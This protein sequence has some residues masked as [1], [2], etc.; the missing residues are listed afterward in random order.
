MA[1]LLNRADAFAE[2]VLW[3]DTATDLRHIIGGAGDRIGFF[4]A[5]LGGEFQPVRDIVG[6]RAALLAEGHAALR[7]ARGLCLHAFDGVIAVNLLEVP[8]ARLGRPFLRHRAFDFDELQHFFCHYRLQG[9]E[10]C[11]CRGHNHL[12]RGF[13]PIKYHIDIYK[14]VGF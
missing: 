12:A 5:I 4:Q 9:K 7:T 11:L 6:E 8:F 13:L 2:P 10:T 3:A 14:G 1:G